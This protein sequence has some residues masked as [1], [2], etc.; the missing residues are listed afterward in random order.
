MG[1][2]VGQELKESRYFK[3]AFVDYPD[4]LNTFIPRVVT[5]VDSGKR[6]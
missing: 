3:Q 2:W 6:R 4:I 5:N 1:G